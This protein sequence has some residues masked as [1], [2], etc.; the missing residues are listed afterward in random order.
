MTMFL[1]KAYGFSAPS[2]PLQFGMSGWRDNACEVL[3]DGDLVVVVGTKEPPTDSAEQGRL[4]GLVEPTK[5]A[6]ASLDFEIEIAPHDFE[7]G[8]YRWPYALVIRRAWLLVERPLLR[9]VSSRA[10]NI[11]AAAGIVP[12]HGDEEDRI[13]KL[14]R[15]EIE[16][17]TPLRIQARLD[18]S[19]VARKR[20]APPPTTVR[21]G[22]MHVRRAPAY[23]YAMEIRGASHIAFKIGW[24]FDYKARARQ[25][26]LYA[27]PTIG[28][29]SYNVI[30]VELWETARKA[31]RMEQ[32]LLKSFDDNRHPANREIVNGISREQ[33]NFAW[34]DSILRLRRNT[35]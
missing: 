18:G 25:F 31:F 32:N 3:Q 7:N 17:L 6:V 2:G 22:V 16:V 11:N 14:E 5:E 27:M 20:N 1:T 15:Q 12:L 8:E 13:L 35:G 33:L 24:A 9:E 19:E 30:L 23:T 4:L 10:F 34:G 26:N 29:L 28:G 21:T